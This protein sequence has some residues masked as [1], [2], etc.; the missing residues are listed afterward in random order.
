MAN[1]AVII[2]N[3]NTPNYC[4]QLISSIDKYCNLSNLEIIVIDNNS[5]NK[6]I[7]DI[8]GKSVRTFWL[9]KNIG[10]AAACN[11]GAS[12]T[13]ADYLLFANSDCRLNSDIITSMLNYLQQ[14]PNCAACSPQLVKTDGTVH[15]SIRKLPTHNNIRS[16]RGSLIK[17]KQKYTIEADE[18]RK[19]V[20]AMAATFFMIRLSD[21]IQLDGFDKRFFMYV[22]DTDLCYRLK[23]IGKSLTY[24]GDLQIIHHWGASTKIKPTKMILMHHISIKKYFTKHFPKKKLAN[25]F[26]KLQLLV[27]FLLIFIKR[28]IGISMRLM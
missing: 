22:E 25:L 5:H 9:N 8:N 21:F 14:N 16:S 27:N 24:L 19:D 23:D 11:L 12:Y 4:S 17:S 3:Y 20:E 7:P 15:S 28:S 26:L 2:I 6:Y 18:S 10:F 13:K 1:V